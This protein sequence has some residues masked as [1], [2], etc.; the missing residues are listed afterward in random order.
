MAAFCGK[1]QKTRS[2]TVCPSFRGQKSVFELSFQ[3]IFKKHHARSS[4]KESCGLAQEHHFSAYRAAD[5]SKSREIETEDSAPGEHAKKFLGAESGGKVSYV[6]VSQNAVFVAKQTFWAHIDV[7]GGFRPRFYGTFCRSRSGEHIRV[8][9]VPG[10]V[11]RKTPTRQ[12]SD[13][14][15]QDDKPEPHIRPREAAPQPPHAHTRRN[16]IIRSGRRTPLT[17]TNL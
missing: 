16:G 9:P 17:P 5:A 11:P 8:V 4:K 14:T 3:L 6:V 7:D 10:S 15:R 13:K 1:S 2:S 12:A